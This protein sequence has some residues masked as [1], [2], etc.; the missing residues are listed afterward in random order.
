MVASE[1]KGR[2]KEL[3]QSKYSKV[4]LPLPLYSRDYTHITQF[5]V[6]KLMRYCPKHRSLILSEFHGHVLRL[7]LRREAGQV[8]S[9]SF[10][11]YTNAAEKAL[12]LR[13]FYGKEVVLFVPQQEGTKTG[14]RAILEGLDADR[15]KRI[16]A[17]TKE[18]IQLMCVLFNLRPVSC[19]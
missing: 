3:A 7:L 19:I 1:L 11:L 9:D 4:S 8:I 2:F 13:E 6:L 15:Q 17:A 10:E 14:L 12:L 5:L 18:N 16:L